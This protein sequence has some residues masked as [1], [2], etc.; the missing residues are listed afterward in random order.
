MSVLLPSGHFPNSSP[1]ISS[2]EVWPSAQ[3]SSIQVNNYLKLNE[4]IV[5]GEVVF[6][7]ITVSG[8]AN[9]E[10]GVHITGGGD[11]T[12]PSNGSLVI[13]GGIGISGSVNVGGNVSATVI[14]SLSDERQKKEITIIEDALGIVK[15]VQAVKYKFR[16]FNKKVTPDKRYHYGVLAQDLKE[17]GLADLVTENKSGQLTV[18]Y[19][20]IVGILLKSVQELD[21]KLDKV[22]EK[23][24]SLSTC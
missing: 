6:E 21:Q 10:G 24:E 14:N 17:N 1:P 2:I 19:N 7:N 8:F 12:N 11:S 9:F 20:D 22:L 18:N 16:H 5:T 4:I 13:D 15:G 3:F 23:L